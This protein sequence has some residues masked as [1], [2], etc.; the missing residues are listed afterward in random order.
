M[1]RPVNIIISGI[2][3]C[4]N[5]F[6]SNCIFAHPV[7]SVIGVLIMSDEGYEYDCCH[8]I[9]NHAEI[10][11]SSPLTM[12]DPKL[13][14]CGIIVHKQYFIQGYY[15]IIIY[16]PIT[17]IYHLCVNF[18]EANEFYVQHYPWSC[19][20]LAGHKVEPTSSCSCTAFREWSLA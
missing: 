9:Y 6:H 16:Y 3:K 20:I 8:N 2:Q 4:T 13:S 11:T 19:L 14:Y 5:N 12:S 17:I 18:S 10:L 1:M 7:S 15:F